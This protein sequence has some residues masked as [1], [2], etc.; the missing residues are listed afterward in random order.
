MYVYHVVLFKVRLVKY[1]RNV[2]S[3]RWVLT[4]QQYM[5]QRLLPLRKHRYIIVTIAAQNDLVADVFGTI[6]WTSAHSFQFT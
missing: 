2:G 4:W 3:I 5:T 6:L 1:L